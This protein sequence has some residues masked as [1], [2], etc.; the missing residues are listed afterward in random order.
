MF[1]VGQQVTVIDGGW[2]GTIHS[3]DADERFAYIQF[4]DRPD[5][6]PYAFEAIT[7]SMFGTLTDDER[8]ALSSK[9]ADWGHRFAEIGNPMAFA[10]LALEKDPYTDGPIWTAAR[11]YQE[12]MSE[13]YAIRAELVGA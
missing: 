12:A 6:L 9:L 10:S 2:T 4:P 11:R 7:G 13:I 3:I 8:Q 5:R 1:Q